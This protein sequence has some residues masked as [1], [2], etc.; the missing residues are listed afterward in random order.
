MI[1]NIRWLAVLCGVGLLAGEI[2]PCAAQSLG[3]QADVS[4]GMNAAVGIWRFAPGRWGLLRVRVVNRSDDPVETTTVA[5]F[6]AAPGLQFARRLWTPAKST[7]QATCPVLAPDN[8]PDKDSTEIEWFQLDD[9]G[10]RETL[11]PRRSGRMLGDFPVSVNTTSPVTGIMNNRDDSDA[12][13]VDDMVL[14]MRFL[15]RRYEP[16]ARIHGDFSPEL[17]EGYDGLDQL[18]LADDRLA[19]DSAG[20]AALRHWVCGGGRL[21]VMLDR[22]D[23]AMVEL[24]LGDAFRCEVVDRVGL[25]EVLVQNAPSEFGHEADARREF[26]H[27]L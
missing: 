26:G 11:S 27:K 18:V 15:I 2:S 5:F 14:A 22:V 12:E 19:F 6:S 16:L 3:E 21:W 1:T 4:L 7:R 24:L 10:S 23:P 9:S 8:L 25:T 20:M 17:A 13:A